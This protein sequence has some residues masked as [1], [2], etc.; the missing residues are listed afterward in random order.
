MAYGE[1]ETQNSLAM[2]ED[3]VGRKILDTATAIISRETH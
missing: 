2:V 1:D 3:H